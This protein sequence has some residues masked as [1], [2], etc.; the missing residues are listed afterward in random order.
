MVED[1]TAEGMLPDFQ[2][3]GGG[4]AF[5]GLTSLIVMG[6]KFNRNYAESYGGALL[7]WVGSIDT[8]HSIAYNTVG[9]E[10]S[11]LARNLRCV[12]GVHIP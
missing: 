1:N 3:Q 6:S 4:L 7:L 10:N 2:P 5:Y 9:H 12:C 11:V 8:L